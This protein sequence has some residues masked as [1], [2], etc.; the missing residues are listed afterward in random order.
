MIELRY[1]FATLRA[2]YLRAGTGLVLSLGPAAMVPG[3]SAALYVLLPAALLFLAFGLR[4]W[5]RQISRVWLDEAGISLF[6]PRRV[7]LAW[8]DIRALKLGYY[9]VRTDRT[10]GWMQLTLKGADKTI[11]IDSSL[12]EFEQLVRRAASAAQH[13][14]AKLSEATRTNL[15]ALNIAVAEPSPSAEAAA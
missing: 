6:S 4:T 11:R 7:S 12:D 13:N 15:A 9:A 10:G 8:E 5:R 1:R 3:G 14:G 2:D